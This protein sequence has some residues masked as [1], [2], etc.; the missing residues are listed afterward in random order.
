VTN[1]TLTLGTDTLFNFNGSTPTGVG[2]DTTKL[3]VTDDFA[4]AEPVS[5]LDAVPIL[6][7]PTGTLNAT[8]KASA[9]VGTAFNGPIAT[10]SYDVAAAQASQFK[11]TI[12]WG[13]GHIT[14]GTV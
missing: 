4:Y 7:G 1:V 6:P 10:F 14:N 8:A 9:N 11:A 3:V 13:D 12:N 5:I 2:T